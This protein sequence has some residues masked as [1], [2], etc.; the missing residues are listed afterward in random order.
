MGGLH[1]RAG[2]RRRPQGDPDA[3]RLTQRA[4]PLAVLPIYFFRMR[5]DIG[6]PRHSVAMDAQGPPFEIA[7]RPLAIC[8]D[9][10]QFRKACRDRCEELRVARTTIDLV[11]G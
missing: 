3:P 4:G 6:R 9:W 7:F 10:D 8:R 2:E 1:S 11:G 5:C